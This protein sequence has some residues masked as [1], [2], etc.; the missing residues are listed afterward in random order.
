VA[1]SSSEGK[2]L[3]KDWLQHLA[4]PLKFRTFLDVGCGAGGYGK[5]IREVYGET[6]IVLAGVEVFPEYITRYNLSSIYSIIIPTDIRQAVELLPNFDL[7]IMGDILEHLD[8]KDAVEIVDKL[9]PKCK[10]LWGALPVKVK[11]RAWSTGYAQPECDY[12]ENPFNLHR[13][14]W[15]GAEVLEEFKPLWLVPYCQVGCFL[16]EGGVPCGI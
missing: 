3:F 4:L 16:V 1:F 11:G 5:I 13:Y 12:A 8:K 14:D 15:S 6:P 10:F 2:G 9:R 7:I